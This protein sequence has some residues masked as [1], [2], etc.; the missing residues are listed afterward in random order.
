[1]TWFIK[2]FITSDPDLLRDIIR[3]AILGVLMQ[4]D[5]DVIIDNINAGI[6]PEEVI[7]IGKTRLPELFKLNDPTVKGYVKK[8]L[9]VENVLQWLS[10]EAEN[11]VDDA[12]REH[13]LAIYAVLIQD[14]GMKWL[15]QFL[16]YIRDNFDRIMEGTQ[17]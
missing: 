2:G 7:N 4:L 15:D 13:L 14:N 17:T 16:K 6:R 1:M 12:E 5:I 3:G 8:Y 10:D 11:T 9:T